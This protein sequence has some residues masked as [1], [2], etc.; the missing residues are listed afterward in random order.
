MSEDFSVNHLWII[1]LK[2]VIR[3]AYQDDFRTAVQLVLH[4]TDAVTVVIRV[5]VHLCL[6]QL[7][8]GG[9]GYH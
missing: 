2:V 5:R 4:R 6:C 3:V 8:T 1:R 9:M 7:A